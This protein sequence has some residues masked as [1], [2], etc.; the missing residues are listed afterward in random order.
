MVKKPLKVGFDLDGVLLYNPARIVRPFIAHV[1]KQFFPQ[2]KTTFHI[3]QGEIEK[4]LWEFLH[5]SSFFISPGF[6]DIKELVQLKKI[7]GYIITARYSFLQG[8]FETW[9]RKLEAKRWFK[10]S[11]MN[12]SNMQ[13]HLYKEK[14]VKRYNL[15]YFIEDN[16]DIV[17]YLNKTCKHTSVFWIYNVFDRGI[18]YK[19]KFPSLS[20]A[21]KEIGRK[22]K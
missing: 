12:S 17:K 1:K 10:A 22:V 13:P 15:D 5:L 14:M 4:R 3:P 16:W 8:N 19:F 20:E 11:I 18:D 2:E 21:V 6:T 9:K 7:D